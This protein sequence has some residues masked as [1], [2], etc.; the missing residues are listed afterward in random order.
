MII[1]SKKNCLKK[2]LKKIEILHKKDKCL[3]IS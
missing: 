2:K 1:L 3:L